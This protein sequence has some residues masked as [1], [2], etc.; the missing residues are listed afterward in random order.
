MPC[1][2]LFQE[3]FK[4]ECVYLMTVGMTSAVNR[5]EREAAA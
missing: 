4:K 5:M 1:I 3:E 2:L